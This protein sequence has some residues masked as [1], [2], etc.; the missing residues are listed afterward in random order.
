MSPSGIPL[1]SPLLQLPSWALALVVLFLAALV[2]VAVRVVLETVAT[3]LARKTRTRADE[4]LIEATRRPVTIVLF[5]L[6]VRVAL[7]LAALPPRYGAL[8]SRAVVVL[9][10]LVTAYGIGA[11]L[12]AL[13][14]EYAPVSP[15]LAPVA[16]FL[17]GLTRGVVGFLGLLVAL[18]SVGI[19]ITPI[20]ASL[21]VGSVAVALALQET[22]GNFFA[23]IALLADRPIRVGEFV[24]IE[25]DVEGRVVEI[26][27]RTT[28]I[29]DFSN[30]LAILPNA[31]LARATIRNYNRPGVDELVGVRLLVSHGTRLEHAL[32]AARRALE[33]MGGTVQVTA[34]EPAGIELTGYVPVPERPARVGTKARALEAIALA[35]QEDAIEPARLPSPGAPPKVS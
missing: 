35:F 8:P 12:L 28:S 17:A 21:G 24:R 16:G 29:L 33:P 30:N 14:R 5:L 18:D 25:P 11:A 22:L 15:R 31:V 7:D 3:R 32:A 9:T 6:G 27:W 1:P 2:A 23:G 4:I 26:G 20:L 34:I 10:V 19:S 13:L